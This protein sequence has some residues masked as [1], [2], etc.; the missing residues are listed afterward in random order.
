MD[1]KE[2]ES[3][4]DYNELDLLYKLIEIANNSKKRTEQIL[5][6]N[7]QAGVDVRKS[8]QDIKMITEIMRDKIQLRKFN[9]TEDEYTRLNKAIN[10]EKERL[11]REEE[12]I[13]R[14]EKT[15]SSM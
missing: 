11:K 1:L 13:K 7:K 3:L 8:L 12:K 2:L 5:K 15:R 4:R 9:K 14:L 6:G 10:K